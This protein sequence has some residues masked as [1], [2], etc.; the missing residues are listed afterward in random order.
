MDIQKL[1]YFFCAADTGNFTQAAKQ[2]QIAQ[3]TM[4]KYIANLEDEF[5]CSLFI[6]TIK[7][8]ELTADGRRFYRHAKKLSAGY[9]ELLRVMNRAEDHSELKLGIDGLHLYIDILKD[10]EEKRPDIRL[11]IQIGTSAELTQKLLHQEL[12]AVLIPDVLLTDIG[13]SSGLKCE[14]LLV[15]PDSLVFS[16]AALNRAGSTENAIRSLPFITKSADPAYHEFCREHLR[17]AYGVSFEKVTVIGSQTDQNSLLRLSQGFSILTD[18]EF[19][20]DRD[21]FVFLPLGTDFREVLQIVYNTRHMTP[22]LKI[23]LQFISANR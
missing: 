16:K 7:G 8:C 20:S 15:A 12:H 2:C 23:L 18:T 3:T 6:R 13:K 4:S 11:R 22:P 5:G 14:N 19:P 1:D 9:T 17:A 21:E 10:F